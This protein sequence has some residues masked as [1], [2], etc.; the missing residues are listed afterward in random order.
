M[1]GGDAVNSALARALTLKIRL[2]AI[3][4]LGFD[5][6]T[7]IKEV[8]KKNSYLFHQEKEG[9]EIVFMEPLLCARRPAGAG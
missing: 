5:Y 4:L 9:K 1:C 7:I 2:F 3:S 8:K 6:L